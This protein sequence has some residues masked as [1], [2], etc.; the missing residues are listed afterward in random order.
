[1]A[2]VGRPVLRRAGF[3][4]VAAELL[5]QVLHGTRGQMQ[6][7]RNGAAIESFGVE[8]SDVLA[9]GPGNGSRHDQTSSEREPRCLRRV[10]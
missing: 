3:A 5:Q 6:A 9:D 1:L 4:A 7:P 8:G 10:N 2:R